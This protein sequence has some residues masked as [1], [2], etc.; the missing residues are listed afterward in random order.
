[1]RAND[2]LDS[3]D[4][5]MAKQLHYLSFNNMFYCSS[6]WSFPTVHY[7]VIVLFFPSY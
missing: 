7:A 2:G 5:A 3:S 6:L 4:T 1:M